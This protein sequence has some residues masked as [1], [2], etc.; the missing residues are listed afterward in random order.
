MRVPYEID[1]AA[2][3]KYYSNQ[4][5]GA[6]IEIYRASPIQGGNGL[7]SVLGGL[8]R[9]ALP[10][11]RNVVS[12]AAPHVLRTGLRVASDYASGQTL[13]SAIK[14]RAAETMGDVIN[15]AS[16]P[17]IRRR[18][19]ALKGTRRK[20]PRGC[21]IASRPGKRNSRYNRLYDDDEAY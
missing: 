20:H 4:G 7:G 18:G 3:C 21:S 9:A 15:S 1:H 12:R 5:G 8:F 16:R 10:V 19:N 13:G 17:L 2:C 6:D 14:T 11:I